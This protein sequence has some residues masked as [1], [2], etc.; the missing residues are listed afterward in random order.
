MMCLLFND[1]E[2]T[3]K[4][5]TATAFTPIEEE[6]G[7]EADGVMMGCLSGTLTAPLAPTIYGNKIID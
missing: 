4:R 1:F 5:P 6:E 7:G 2:L 3:D